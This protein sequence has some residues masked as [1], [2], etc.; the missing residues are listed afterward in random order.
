MNGSFGSFLSLGT[1]WRFEFWWRHVIVFFF[2]NWEHCASYSILIIQFLER[3]GVCG[4][5]LHPHGVCAGIKLRNPSSIGWSHS[6]T[7][8]NLLHNV[9]I[10]WACSNQRKVILS[11][12]LCGWVPTG[13][14]PIIDIFITLA[15]HLAVLRALLRW[16]ITTA[17]TLDSCVLF[18]SH[19]F[20]PYVNVCKRILLNLS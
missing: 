14:T 1:F 19:V 18:H 20:N 2:S 3:L 8:I 4:W 17:H 15:S 7:H 9:L 12:I 10:F 16:L 13:T 11:P 5:F 6:F